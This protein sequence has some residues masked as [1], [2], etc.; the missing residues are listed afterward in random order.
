MYRWSMRRARI[1][2]IWWSSKCR[3]ACRLDWAS[4]WYTL[5]HLV[6][7]ILF[8]RWKPAPHVC[9]L[10]GM[11]PAGSSRKSCCSYCTLL[12]L[13]GNIKIT[14]QVNAGFFYSS[15]E[16][17]EKLVEHETQCTWRSLRWKRFVGVAFCF[18]VFRNMILNFLGRIRILIS[19]LL[20]HV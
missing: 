18:S 6:D 19:T 8:T 2:G 1:D 7:P 20:K 14:S 10:A 12:F 4:S 15:A 17:R 9:V 16:Q 3:E 5:F 11:D 13:T